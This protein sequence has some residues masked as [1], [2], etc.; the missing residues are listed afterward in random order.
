MKKILP[1]LSLAFLA[2]A[3]TTTPQADE[4]ETAAAAMLN[5]VPAFN[6][7]TVGLAA[8]QQWKSQNELA[9][10]AQFE[11][12]P[13]AVAPK[14]Q[15]TVAYQ[16]PRKA[17]A[18]KKTTAPRASA[19]APV[20]QGQVYNGDEGTSVANETVNEAKAEKEGWSKAA[21]GAAIGTTAGAAAGAIIGKK[22]RVLGGV[23]GGVVGGAV[24][25]GVGRKMDKKD[26]RY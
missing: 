15:Q 3:C 7:D 14:K 25:Y 2:T 10:A 19:P 18:K 8:Y 24:G 26:G 13:Q 23:I 9:N 12:A 21:K 22:N 5:A 4:K 6:P 17:V 20:S 16:A 1:I 11:A